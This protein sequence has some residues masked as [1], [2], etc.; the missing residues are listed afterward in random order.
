MAYAWGTNKVS[1]VR[2]LYNIP[3]EGEGSITVLAQIENFFLLNNFM[4]TKK[5]IIYHLPRDS[6]IKELQE[7]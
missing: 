5:E 2:G 7:Y 3:A 6:L 4:T 1:G